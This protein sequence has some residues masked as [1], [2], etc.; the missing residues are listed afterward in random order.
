MGSVDFDGVA[1]DEPGVS[2]DQSEGFGAVDGPLRAAPDRCDYLVLSG[3][4][5]SEI[6][7][8][9]AGLHSEVGGAAG[10]VGDLGGVDHGLGGNTPTVEAGAT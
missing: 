5:R 3:H 1:V 4:H 8:D 7:S 9:W 2:A 10:E 6:D